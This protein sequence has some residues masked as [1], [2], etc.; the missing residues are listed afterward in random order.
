MASLKI[1]P[2]KITDNSA[3]SFDKF[4]L[5]FERYLRILKPKE[6]DKLDL[7]LL[8]VG[9]CLAG[10]YDELEWKELSGEEKNAGMTE[11]RRAK[12]FISKKLS[13]GKNIL[14][15]R[16][17]LYSSKQKIGQSIDEYVSQ[18]RQI[19]QYCSFPPSFT[20]EALRDAFCQ[21]LESDSNRKAVCHAFAL[22]N[23]S[24]NTFSLEDA[25]AAVQVEES[26]NSAMGSIDNSQGSEISAVHVSNGNKACFWCGSKILHGRKWSCLFELQRNGSF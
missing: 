6:E 2:P 17:R 16:I 23:K 11:Y 21:G 25:V 9:E 14:S 24:N 5:Q 4:I 12:E 15:E 1:D 13:G 18:L 22:F 7:F 26:A 19:A 8:S 10:Y 20:N 3:E